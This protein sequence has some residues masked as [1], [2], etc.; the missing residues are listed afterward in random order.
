MMMPPWIWECGIDPLSDMQ[1]WDCRKCS[2]ILISGV[3]LYTIELSVTLDS[4]LVYPWS[5]SLHF[6]LQYERLSSLLADRLQ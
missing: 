1:S 4:Q 5:V 2:G 6:E 3:V